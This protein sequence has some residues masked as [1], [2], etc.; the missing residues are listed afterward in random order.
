MAHRA[1]H[2]TRNKR[3]ASYYNPEKERGSTRVGTR[4]FMKM[5][6]IGTPDLQ[7]LVGFLAGSM[8][9]ELGPGDG[10]KEF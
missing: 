4:K 8:A 10:E 1:E 2:K 7:L 3:L 5:R 9:A 6:S